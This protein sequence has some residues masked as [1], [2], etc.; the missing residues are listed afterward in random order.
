[1]PTIKLE[2]TTTAP[3]KAFKKTKINPRVVKMNTFLLFRKYGIDKR[4]H[5]KTSR[6]VTAPQSL[7][8][9]STYAFKT[10]NSCDSFK[11][12]LFSISAALLAKP[13]FF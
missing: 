13:I 3:S 8:M 11:D 5:A 9:Y 12:V 10:L 1:M 7:L 2:L 6:P 4:K